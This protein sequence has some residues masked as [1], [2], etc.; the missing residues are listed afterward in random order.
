[1]GPVVHSTVLL[2]RDEC[3]VPVMMFCSCASSSDVVFFFPT[4]PLIVVM[5][6]GRECRIRPA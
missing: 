1:M 4:T 3:E 2:E 6:A 5:V